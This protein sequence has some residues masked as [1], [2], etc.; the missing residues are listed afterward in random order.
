MLLVK[1]RFFTHRERNC[2]LLKSISILQ[3]IRINV[4]YN[5][6]CYMQSYQSETPAMDSGFKQIDNAC[7]AEP[8]GRMVLNTW[9]YLGPIC[10]KDLFTPIVLFVL[11][12]SIAAMIFISNDSN[13]LFLIYHRRLELVDHMQF[14]WFVIYLTSRN[15]SI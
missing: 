1:V 8:L 2:K 6:N 9:L 12:C 3:N 5:Y 13:T 10:Y 4:L 7:T 15:F 14:C 11:F